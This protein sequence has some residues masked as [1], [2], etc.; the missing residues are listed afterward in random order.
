VLGIDPISEMNLQLFDIQAIPGRGKGLVA[1]FNIAPGKRVLCEKPLFT[2]PNLSPLAV[3]EKSLA[4]KLKT[5][6]RVEQRQ[7]LSLHNNFPGKYPFSGIMKTNALPCGPD[8][9]IGGVYPTICL[10]NHSCLP[11]AHN[12]WN[13]DAKCET[14]HAIRYIKSGEEIT[15][16]YDK[17][18]P[19]AARRSHLKDAFG[20]VCSCTLCSQ[21]SSDLHISDTRRL[22]IKNLD[23]AIGD[24]ERVM[25]K[26]EDCLADCHLLLQVLEAEYKGGAGALMAR[27]YY[28]AFQISI[29]HGDQARASVFAER[30][31]RSRIICEGED[32]PETRQIKALMDNPAMHRNFGAS[33][34]WQTNKRLVPKG[35]NKDEYEKWLWRRER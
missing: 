27:L 17:G 22:Q 5:L 7:F 14:I 16:S 34:R 11:N 29:T 23:D 3:M 6:S 28:D 4:T 24:S 2:T 30:S 31:H 9:I 33:R 8:F 35:L 25:N 18:G 20:F 1:R 15:I 13:S 32:S 21:P 12:S 10:I 19:S 26:P